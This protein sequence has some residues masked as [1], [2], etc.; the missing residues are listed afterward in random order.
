M[1]CVYQFELTVPDAVVDVNRHINNV[2]YV[3]WMQEAAIRHSDASGCTRMTRAAGAMWVARTHRIEY[4]RPGFAGD[5]LAVRTWVADFRRVRSLRRYQFTRIADQVTLAEGETDWVFVDAV[6][7][8][9]ESSPWKSSRPFRSSRGMEAGALDVFSIVRHDL[10]DMTTNQ[11]S[12]RRFTKEFRTVR[13][14][15][16][17]VMD[18]GQVL[19]TWT[20]APSKSVPVDFAERARKDSAAVLPVSFAVILKE[21]KKR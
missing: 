5:V 11:I 7:G 1:D 17:Q 15:P 18:R 9:R 14:R 6:T 20:P 13:T 21:G 8:R 16:L 10:S 2:A 12:T 3:Q 4:L 19:G